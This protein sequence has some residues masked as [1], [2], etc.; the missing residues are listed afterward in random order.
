[1]YIHTDACMLLPYLRCTATGPDQDSAVVMPALED[2]VHLASLGDSTKMFEV[3][4]HV[5]S[6]ALLVRL[7][8]WTFKWDGEKKE[9][10]NCLIC[11][12]EAQWEI[13]VCSQYMYGV[14]AN[15][16]FRFC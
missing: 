1:M 4:I 3:W 5:A 10:G 16:I 15:R 9:R 12:T 14:L 7:V 2:C 8:L 11:F 6:T 13:L